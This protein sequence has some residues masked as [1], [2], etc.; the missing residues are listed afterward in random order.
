[1]PADVRPMALAITT[2]AACALPLFFTS[3]LAL[4]IQRDLGLT[5]RDIGVAITG[6][7]IVATLGSLA[8]GGLAD[9]IGGARAVRLAGALVAAGSLGIAIVAESFAVFVALLCVTALGNAVLTPSISSVV[10]GRLRPERRGT[11]FGLQQSG[12]PLASVVAG[13]ALPTVGAALG[14]R[15]VFALGAVAVLAATGNVTEA[16]ARQPRQ[17]DA[18]RPREADA[19]DTP[20][21]PAAGCAP[22]WP[23]IVGATLA[24]A[25]A[26]G[27]VA[28]VV[29]FGVASGL[30][31]AAAGLVLAAASV[32]CV[33]T[34]IWFGIL[35]DRRPRPRRARIPVLVLAG[36]VGF[37]LLAADAPTT[38]V[39]GCLLALGIGWGW[40]GLYV[41][42]AVEHAAGTPGRAVGVAVSATFAGAML[43]P[44]FVG[45]LAEATSFEVTWL[46]CA[47]LALAAAAA[48]HRGPPSGVAA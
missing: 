46:A 31:S 17:R 38:T 20:V 39:I 41:L 15:W 44:I 3:A 1:M 22:P 45:V 28:Y 19:T 30:S 6:F 42:A 5:D 33:A 7:W 23:A 16:D 14:W 9:R 4:G 12:P 25:V 21:A 47:G 35:A 13:I 37:M 34:R 40:T 24:S 8:F 10:V 29:V 11:T 36:V 43:G 26:S 27:L 2:M 48:L 18:M 32:T